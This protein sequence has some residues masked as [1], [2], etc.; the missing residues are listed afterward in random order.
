MILVSF[1]LEDNVLSDDIKICYIF[2]FYKSNENQVFHF[3]GD[4]RYN[5]SYDP[6]RL[7]LQQTS[8]D[9]INY[10][11]FLELLKKE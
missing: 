1:F 6:N 3:L 5:W 4:T 2:Y 7:S 11:F 9:Q 10:K 8:W